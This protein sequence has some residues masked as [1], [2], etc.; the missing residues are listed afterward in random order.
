MD[1][2]KFLEKLIKTCK[3]VITEPLV[4]NRNLNLLMRVLHLKIPMIYWRGEEV[5]IRLPITMSQTVLK[6]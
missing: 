3:V 4:K 5:E 6:T 2:C 1:L